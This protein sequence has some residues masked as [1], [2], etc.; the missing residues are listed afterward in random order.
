MRKGMGIFFVF[1]C[2]PLFLFSPFNSISS[3]KYVWTIGLL[4]DRIVQIA[5]KNRWFVFVAEE[6][7]L[8]GVLSRS[9]RICLDNGK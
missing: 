5:S 3:P 7:Q 9:N 6:L 1:F 8:R 4:H 2:V